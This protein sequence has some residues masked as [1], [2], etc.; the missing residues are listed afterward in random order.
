MYVFIDKIL[1]FFK[2][3]EWVKKV[4]GLLPSRQTQQTHCFILSFLITK[5]PFISLFFLKF[6]WIF[7]LHF[8]CYSLFLSRSPLRKTPIESSLPLTLWGCSPH[9]CTHSLPWHFSTLGHRIPTGPRATPITDVQQ[10]HTLL[11]MQ[12][13]QRSLHVYSGWW[14]S[15]RKLQEFWQVDTIVPPMG[16]QILSAPSVLSLTPPLGIQW[17]IHWTVLSPMVGW[18]HSSASVFVWLWKNLS[19][20]NYVRLC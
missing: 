14:S 2:P 19:G 16:M 11:H 12:P 4:F 6:H 10:G 18:E 20:D 17:S 9:P 5:S 1:N 13:S 7:Y 15:P 3:S 8:K